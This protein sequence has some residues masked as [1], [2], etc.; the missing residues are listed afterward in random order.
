MSALGLIETNGLLA[1]IE[2][3]DAMLKTAD[4]RLLERHFVGAGLVTVTV[5]GE[6]AAVRAAVDA[7]VATARAIRDDAVVS[8]HVIARPDAELGR[9]VTVACAPD[10]GPETRIFPAAASAPTPPCPGTGGSAGMAALRSRG[11]DISRLKKMSLARLREL[12]RGTDG[13][14]MTR[15]ALES[16]RKNELIETLLK[17]YR[18]EEE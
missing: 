15:E 16:A 8:A 1:A 18:Q 3:A 4:V 12:A 10:G 5:T 2:C 11:R 17:A 14:T 13:L 9:V 7:A 6:V